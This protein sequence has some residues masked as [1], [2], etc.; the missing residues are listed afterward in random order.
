M[1]KNRLTLVVTAVV[2]FFSGNIKAQEFSKVSDVK[3]A[4]VNFT[5]LANYYKAHPLP[6]VKRMPID[7]DELEAHRHRHS[8]DPSQVHLINRADR[9]SGGLAR[10]T[11]L[12]ASP[13]PIDSFL[14]TLSS[15][16]SIPPDT[17][18]AVDSQYCVTAINT[19]IHIQTR[20]GSNVS[21]IS[22]DGFWA[23]ILPAGT[24]TFD[25]RI[26]YDPYNR[27]WILITDAVNSTGFT[28]S[29]VLVGVSATYDPTGTWHLYSVSVDGTGSSWMD[30]PNA[31]FNNRF[32]AVTG[33]MFPNSAGGA[34]GAVAFI[35]D[36]A[37][38][39]AGL[40]V[41][42]TRY[43][44]SSSFAIA[45]ALT[46]DTTVT[47]LFALESWDGATG[48]LRL[49]K[50]A[51]PTSAPTMTT[52]GYPATTSHWRG[53]PPGSGGFAK[54]VGTTATIESGDDRITS[55][56]YR[57]NTL[58][59][60]HTAFLPATGTITRSGIMWWQVDTLAVPVQNGIIQDAN[61]PKY[62]VYS[63]IAVNS[64][65]DV[66]VGYGYLSAAIHPSCGYSLHMHTDPLD[67][68]RA[69]HI[70]RS[71]VATYNTTFGGGRNRWGDYSNT[72]VD[73]RNDI[74]FWTIQESS[75]T[76]TTAN[77]DTWWANVQF[78]PKP[79]APVLS[80]IP[81]APCPGDTVTYTVDT[82]PGAT[83]YVWYLSG[84]G[85]SGSS[86]TNSITVVAGTGIGTFVVYAYNACGQGE[87][88]VIKITPQ[89]LPTRLSIN[90]IT[91]PC[92]GGVPPV[93]S[94]TSFYTTSYSWSA[95]NNGWSGTSGSTSLT[96]TMGTGTGMIICSAN[97][98]CG[99]ILDTIYVTPLPVPVTT[100]S[101]TAHTE[102]A[103]VSD[104]ITFTG[105]APA[106]STYTWDFGGGVGVPGTGAGPQAVT[107]ATVGVK[108]VV[109]TVDNGGCNSSSTD[110][111]NVIANVGVK[112][113]NIKDIEVSVMPNPNKG[114]FQLV[115]GNA[116]NKTINV[117]MIDIQGR[118][119]YA[120]QIQPGINKFNVQAE[121]LPGGIY[122]VILDCDGSEVT[123]K[124]TIVR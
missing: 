105:T 121:N 99:S 19:S 61:G 21:V 33:N 7:E 13:A 8:V 55:C 116:V 14:A 106:G 93:F 79:Y 4:E 118:E 36:Y 76:G 26:H 101:V 119:V 24:G 70:Y 65:N 114:N 44:L 78:C 96:A 2:L 84:T 52:V 66:L 5:E 40:T 122:S 81:P 57:N 37:R 109:L 6:F 23:S 9:R 45:P 86:T 112:P 29:T 73:P 115:L 38:M 72:C 22:L 100:F 123:K 32:V 71:G 62:F 39:R 28:Q 104:V 3:Q 11:L 94:A 12:P 107:W 64:L 124:V 75:I 102:M 90:T 18:G 110:M 25:P 42:P 16:S 27:R 74:D 69:P 41:T 92:I 47:S 30:F 53:N 58:W 67:S 17:H 46:Y 117:R 85:W 89:T 43:N 82:I 20:S 60:S 34:S 97:N 49:W 113:I 10:T 15:G 35:F 1:F 68:M 50:I 98:S 51:G 111:V 56:T 91:P 95:S 120:N 63:S 59:T 77:W 88:R 108:T 83:S 103:H 87:S 31:G 48:K 54:Q 80:A